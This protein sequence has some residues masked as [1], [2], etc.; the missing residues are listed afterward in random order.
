MTDLDVPALLSRMRAAE[1]VRGTENFPVALRVLPARL[2][3]HL[4]A[5]YGY[6][7]FVDDIGDEPMGTV[8]VR[9]LYGGRPVTLSAVAALAPTV[10]ARRLPIGALLRLVDANRV[11]QRV[12]RYDTFD[13]LLDYCTLSADPVGE[14]VLHVFTEPTAEQV[15]L[16]DRIC[17][18]LQLVEH[19]QDIGQD[20]RRGRIY[21]PAEEM[22][23]FGVDEADLDAAVAG[24][25]LR[26]LVEFAA[27][28]AAAWLD[29][30]APLVSTLH[31]WARLAVGGYLAGG[32]AALGVLVRAGYDPL[33]APPRP[34]GR[35]VFTRWLA[36]SVR[37]A[38]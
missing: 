5:L 29:A 18:G 23:R 24:P 20:R 36:A 13:Q 14:L 30:G 7:R 26:A 32:R 1:S 37:S 10:A 34:T 3:R 27:N 15:A 33:P 35:H 19:L 2:R 11:D 12:T 8:P 28:R 9:D 22:D 38:G 17:T 6:A 25:K 16:S 21:L 31:G 4:R